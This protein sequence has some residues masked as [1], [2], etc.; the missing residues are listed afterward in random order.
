M[1]SEASPSSPVLP[2]DCWCPSAHR[3]HFCLL[4]RRAGFAVGHI[5]IGP[6]VARP[7][8]HRDA[9]DDGYGVGLVRA[10]G[11]FDQVNARAQPIDRQ[12]LRLADDGRRRDQLPARHQLALVQQRNPRK[13]GRPHHLA[14]LAQLALPLAEAV[15]RLIG[16]LAAEEAPHPPPQIEP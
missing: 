3:R 4:N 11:G 7:L 14:L 10:V 1:V 13:P 8:H 9:G 15:P 16:E 2:V 5:Q 6:P 12:L